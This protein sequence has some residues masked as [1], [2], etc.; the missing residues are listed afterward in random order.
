MRLRELEMRLERLEGFPHPSARLEQYQTPA[1]LA[2]RLLFD[3]FMR[4]DIEGKR[5]CDLGSGTGIL[6]IGAALLG[7]GEVVGVEVDADAVEVAQKNAA[8]AGTKARIIAADVKDPE[9]AGLIGNC[10]TVV[11]NPP[12]G[13]QNAHADR[14]F[15]D[16]ALRTGS[17]TYGVFNAGSRRFVQAYIA[18]RGTVTGVIGGKFPIR[19]AFPFHRKARVEIE[20]EILQIVSTTHD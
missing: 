18:G 12:F 20:V 13:A 15:I 19:R 2:A 5:V 7:A 1:S 9:L 14:P 11:M 8:S 17:V 10:D 16:L 3:A 6:A 4:G